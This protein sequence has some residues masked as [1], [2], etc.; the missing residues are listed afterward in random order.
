MRKPPSTSC[1]VW[2]FSWKFCGIGLK[3]AVERRSRGRRARRRSGVRNARAA[4]PNTENTLLKRCSRPTCSAYCVSL[5]SSGER[6]GARNGEQGALRIV[7]I[8]RAQAGVLHPG[9]IGEIGRRQQADGLLPVAGQRLLRQIVGVDRRHALE[10]AAVLVERRI[11]IIDAGQDLRGHPEHRVLDAQARRDRPCLQIG[12]VI[13]RGEAD[14]AADGCRRTRPACSSSRTPPS[15]MRSTPFHSV[16]VKPA[17][18]LAPC[19]LP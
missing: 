18:A 13:G 6:L 17:V 4:R 9:A 19:W 7:A 3:K 12:V 15:T 14:A 10:R 8:P 5:L 2:V 1:E 16:L 11:V